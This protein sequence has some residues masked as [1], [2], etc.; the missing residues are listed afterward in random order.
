MIVV[1]PTIEKVLEAAHM[2]AADTERESAHNYEKDKGRLSDPVRHAGL[3]L[4]PTISARC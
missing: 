4:L 3:V 2:A 1:E